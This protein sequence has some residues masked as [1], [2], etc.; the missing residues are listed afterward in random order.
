[1][2]S[3]LTAADVARALQY[4]SRNG[5]P[6]GGTV[7]ALYRAGSMPGPIDPSLPVRQ[8]RWSRAVIDAYVAGEWDPEQSAWRREL[9]RH[10]DG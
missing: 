7:R 4:L 9:W 8:W 1:M 3:V 2:S 10:S 5:Q 6:N